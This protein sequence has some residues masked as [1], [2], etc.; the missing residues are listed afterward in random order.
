MARADP[1]AETRLKLNCPACGGQ[2]DETLDLTAFF[3]AEVEARAKRL[4]LE[5]HTLASS[6]G[7]SEREILSLSEPR[8]AFYIE[9]A[10][11]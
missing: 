1:M 3:W 10:R 2:W 8:R 5:V 7:W 6:Y 11:S 4:L 9:R